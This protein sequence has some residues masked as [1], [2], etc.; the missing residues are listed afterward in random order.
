MNENKRL[1]RE[2][3]NIS[4]INRMLKEKNKEKDKENKR[5]KRKPKTFA[6]RLEESGIKLKRT[7]RCNAT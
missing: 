1:L 7:I 2:M 3:K 6:K 5:L 4:K